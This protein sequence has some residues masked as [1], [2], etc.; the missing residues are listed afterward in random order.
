M[1]FIWDQKEYFQQVQCELRRWKNHLI[2]LKVILQAVMRIQIRIIGE[3]LDPDPHEGC[4]CVIAYGTGIRIQKAKIAEKIC[5]KGLKTW[6]KF[7][8]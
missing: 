7:F 3:L 1:Y 4:V 2:Y 6:I 8:K 5:Q